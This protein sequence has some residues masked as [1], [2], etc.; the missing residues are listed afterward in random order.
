MAIRGDDASVYPTTQAAADSGIVRAG[1][2]TVYNI[3]VTNTNAAARYIQFFNAVAVPDDAAVPFLSIQVPI[4]GTVSVD[5]GI[6]GLKFSTGICWANSS[7]GATKTIGAA[8][9]L[10]TVVYS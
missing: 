3:L 4:G 6:Y 1:A 2:G 9:S 8:D 10:V 7:T 5:F